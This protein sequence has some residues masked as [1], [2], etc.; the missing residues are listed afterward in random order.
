MVKDATLYHSCLALTRAFACQIQLVPCL[1]EI[2]KRYKPPQT[3]P[4]YSLLKRAKEQAASYQK[5]MQHLASQE[6]DSEVAERLARDV[7]RTYEIVYG[8]I[9]NG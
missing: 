6:E 7:I 1:K 9:N 4:I 5:Q 8:A 3:A 2:D